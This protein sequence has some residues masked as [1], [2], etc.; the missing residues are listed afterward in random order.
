LCKRQLFFTPEFI[1]ALVLLNGEDAASFGSFE[2]TVAA[3]LLHPLA[4]PFEQS[5]AGE[6][7]FLHFIWTYDDI[8]ENEDHLDL[9]I[10]EAIDHMLNNHFVSAIP[11]EY[12][13]LD[14]NYNSDDMTAPK[15]FFSLSSDAATFSNPQ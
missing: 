7:I 5:L 9:R 11:E 15:A 12:L 4:G 3:L 14:S 10:D 2:E 8:P 6:L 13:S 1:Y